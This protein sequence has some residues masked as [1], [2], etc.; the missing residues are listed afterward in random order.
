MERYTDP[1]FTDLFLFWKS[2]PFCIINV[3]PFSSGTIQGRRFS[4]YKRYFYDR[5]ADFKYSFVG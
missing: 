5:M 4:I 3:F 2:Y 1:I